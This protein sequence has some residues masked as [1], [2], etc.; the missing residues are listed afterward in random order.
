MVASTENHHRLVP[1]VRT[2]CW[3]DMTR[4]SNVNVRIVLSPMERKLEQSIFVSLPEA[5][6]PV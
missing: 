3:I 4:F 5:F 6:E 2:K 1:V